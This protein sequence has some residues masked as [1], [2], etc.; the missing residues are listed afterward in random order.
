MKIAIFG[1]SADPPTI[2][3]QAILAYLAEHYDKTIVYASNNPFK[4]HDTPLEHRNRMLELLITSLNISSDKI[5]FA[6][7]VSNR[8]T[9]NT[10]SK[11]R[12][13]WGDTHQLTIVIGADLTEQIF[14]WYQANQLWKNLKI[15]II[16]RDG[17]LIKPETIVSINQSSLG[18]MVAQ[19]QTP[20]FSS[21]DYRLNQKSKV[22]TDAVKEYIH[23]HLLYT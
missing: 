18:C 8:R 17:Y 13:K 3:H 21:T 23:H 4:A 15:L 11:V 2:S 20:A 12:Q 1:T 10:V 19:L 14:S 7:E 5:V 22:L 16:P 6:P 9:I